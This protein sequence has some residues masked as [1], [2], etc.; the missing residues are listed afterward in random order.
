MISL[1]GPLSNKFT[2]FNETRTDSHMFDHPSW[3][4]SFFQNAPRMR[5]CID[6]AKATLLLRVIFVAT[7]STLIHVLH[8][9]AGRGSRG[10]LRSPTC[11]NR[12]SNVTSLHTR[13]NGIW[14]NGIQHANHGASQKWDS[15]TDQL[16]WKKR[17]RIASPIPCT[18]ICRQS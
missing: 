12:G 10:A 5:S 1:G 7:C 3:L 6:I 13:W 11:V 15:D 16:S 8:C 14:W 17:P 4:A 9:E 2:T 18:S